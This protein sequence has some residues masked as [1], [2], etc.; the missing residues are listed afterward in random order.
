VRL[1]LLVGLLFGYWLQM[2][3]RSQRSSD[4]SQEAAL[5]FSIAALEVDAK[6]RVA[7]Y[8]QLYEGIRSAILS[9]R[10]PAGAALPPTRKLAEAFAIGRSTAIAAYEELLAEGYVYAHVG[11]G[12]V[13]ADM[14]PEAQFVARSRDAGSGVVSATPSLSRRATMLM[15]QP[16]SNQST[17]RPFEP[18][19]PDPTQ[20]PRALWA[21]LLSAAVRNERTQ[22]V[23]YGAFAGIEKLRS[24][25]ARYVG[26]AR[27][28][29]CTPDQVVITTGAQAAIDLI[30]RLTLDPGDTAWIEEPGFFGARS[31]FAAAGA[32]VVGIAVDDN[33]IDIK[34]DAPGPPRIIYVTPSHQF[35]LGMT[36]SL[37]RR[38]KLLDH[39]RR[40]GAF[41]VEDDYD[42]EFRYG[43][44]PL[45]SLQGLDCAGLV[46]YVGTFSKTLFPAMR[47]GYLIAPQAVAGAYV[48]GTRRFGLQPP[49][50]VQRALAEF[51][52]GGQYASYIRKMRRIYGE[53]H[54]ALRRALSDLPDGVRLPEASSGMQLPLL[55]PNHWDDQLI[56]SRLDEQGISAFALTRSSID[57]GSP[58]GLLLGFACIPERVIATSARRLLRVVETYAKEMG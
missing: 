13:V 7:L 49:I 53:R 42:S 48:E 37:H 24:E 40:H 2:S 15:Q 45:S 39:A 38:L 43:G 50:S 23:G 51:I 19:L 47:V 34:D 8:R 27:G 6:S 54:E 29:Q 12:T 20:F 10:L 3:R 55:M 31:A 11:R 36:M 56:A 18:G 57:A 46:I 25:I 52:A 5:P 9:G 58:R 1:V 33:G 30:A 21:Q 22:D 35:P 26:E 14:P 44:R 28:V 16:F 17:L 4:Q 32:R 41:I